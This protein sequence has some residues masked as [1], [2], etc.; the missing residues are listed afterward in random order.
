MVAQLGSFM[1]G[2]AE[3]K[4]AIFGRENK[5]AP[6]STATLGST[7]RDEIIQKYGS[8]EETDKRWFDSMESEVYFYHDQ[9]TAK[10]HQLE[11]QFLACEFNGKG[12]LT[13]Y[14]FHESGDAPRNFDENERFKLVK[15]KS[16]RHEVE[17]LLGAPDGKALLPSTIT[18]PAIEMKLGG[19][20]FPLAKPPEEAKEAWQYYSQTLDD[21]LNKSAQKTLTVFF[22]AQGLYVGSSLLQELATKIH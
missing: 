10:T 16:S 6:L 2:C 15:G 19:A 5:L 20:P 14:S 4:E 8:P 21:Y 3:F 18:L 13:A 9:Y 1:V 17:N 7:S 22:D 12:V 11:Y